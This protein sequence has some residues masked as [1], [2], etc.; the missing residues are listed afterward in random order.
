VND[1]GTYLNHPDHRAAGQATL[2]AVFPTAQNPAAF[3]E[4]IRDEGLAPHHVSEVWL[5]FTAA[6][7][8]NYWVDVSDTLDVK[9]RALAAHASQIGEW[10]EN[11]GMQ[12]QITRWAADEAKQ[13][14]QGYLY[15]E[16]FQRVVLKSEEEGEAPT[17]AE[18]LAAQTEG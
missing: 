8:K 1:E 3:R 18:A 9:L 10:A 12:R 5:Y 15:A 7:H 16:A 11:G 4:L 6:A 17:E 13:H 2:D 14:Q